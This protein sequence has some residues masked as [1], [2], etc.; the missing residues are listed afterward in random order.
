LLSAGFDVI[1]FVRSAHTAATLLGPQVELATSLDEI[2]AERRIGAIVNLA[3]ES[4]AGGLWT[5]HRRA[6]LLESRLGVTR[7]LL[8]LVARLEQPPRT[9]LNGSAIGYYGA[10]FDDEPLDEDAPAGRGFQAELCRR[11][12]E[13]AAGAAAH[14]VAVALLRLGVVLGN[15]GGALPSFVRPARWHLGLPFGSGRQWFSWIHRD[16]LLALM[17]LVLERGDL[18]GPINAVAPNAVR[19]AELMRTIA[20]VLGRWQLPGAVPAG[21]LRAALGELAELFVDGQRVVPARAAALGFEFR[22]PALEPALRA[23]LA[24]R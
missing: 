16:D 11:W 14:G 10:R 9:W 1:A 20:A 19:Q 8:R 17:M 4:I 2:G 24:A 18:A 21:A 12:E 5:Q 15:D 3:G 13:M 22:Y 23:L 6:T 7:A